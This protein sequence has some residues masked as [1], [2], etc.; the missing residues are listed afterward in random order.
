MPERLRDPQERAARP[1]V[2]YHASPMNDAASPTPSH[3][4]CP[5]CQAPLRHQARQYR[6]ENGHCYDQAKEGYV[7]LLPSHR[8]R[9][10]SPGDDRQ[11]LLNRREFLDHGYYRPLAEAVAGQ[12]AA[13]IG[14]TPLS[15][16]DTGCGEG[17]YTALIAERL[18]GTGH[19]VGG[20]DIAKDAVRMAARRYPDID[21][22]VASTAA[23]PVADHSLDLITRIFAPGSDSELLRTLRPGGLFIQVTPGPRHLFQ[24]REL[25]YD[26]PREHAAAVIE[27]AGLQHEQTLSVGFPL[28]IDGEGDVARLL[29][30]TPYYWQADAAKQARI[31]ALPRLETQADFRIDC[32]R[33]PSV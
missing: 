4:T 29:S 20:I 13:A 26:N 15:L 10:A 14:G 11:M 22:A 2:G 8:K 27:V 23:L 30:M 33:A 7:N 25:V 19:W 12:C 3:W 9:S 16:L 5:A 24:L 21:F 31:N 1:A 32:Y 17:Y 28:H 6:C 18:P